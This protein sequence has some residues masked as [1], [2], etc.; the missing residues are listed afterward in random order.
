M[1]YQNF[2][3]ADKVFVERLD[4]ERGA[5]HDLGYIDTYDQSHSPETWALLVLRYAGRVGEA[6]EAMLSM[7]SVTIGMSPT[8]VKAT[9]A[10]NRAKFAMSFVKLGAICMAAHAANDWRSSQL[11]PVNPESMYDMA[12]DKEA[13]KSVNTI[14]SVIDESWVEPLAQAFYEEAA[15]SRGFVMDWEAQSEIVRNHFRTAARN[16]SRSAETGA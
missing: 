15:L 6:A 13:S 11:P 10:A 14:V 12:G 5:Q 2:S 1:K 16:L 8:E 4:R 7:G 3:L 9:I